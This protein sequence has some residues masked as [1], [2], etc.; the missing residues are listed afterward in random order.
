MNS[1][2]FLDLGGDFGNFDFG[3]G[4]TVSETYEVTLLW[5]VFDT[6]DLVMTILSNDFALHNSFVQNR[7]PDVGY[8]VITDKK[9]LELYRTADFGFQL[10]NLY[11]ASFGNLVLLS[12]SSDNREHMPLDEPFSN[13][14]TVQDFYRVVKPTELN[15]DTNHGSFFFF[16]SVYRRSHP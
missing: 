2:R 7:G 11:L 5:L 4:L 16:P 6:L 3:I 13:L 14:G 9:H 15:E 8:F 12:A 10:L 1:E